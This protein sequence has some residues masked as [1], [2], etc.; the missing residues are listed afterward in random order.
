MASGSGKLTILM[1]SHKF[2]EV[3]KFADEVTILRRG[4]PAG[5]GQVADLT[6][7]AMARMMVGE[8]PPQ[9]QPARATARAARRRACCE[10]DALCAPTTISA[11]PRSPTSR[12]SVRAGEIVG[13][14]GVSGNG[15]EELVE[16]LAGQ[17]V[18]RARARSPSAA[19]RYR[20]RRDEMRARR[21][22]AC[23]TSRCATPASAAMS[24]AENIGFRRFD[25]HPFTR[26]GALVSG[27]ALR[28]NARSA[29]RRVRHP[30]A[31]APTRRS[32]ACRA[33]T[34]SAR[35]WRASCRRRRAADRLEPLLRP[36]LRGG[37]RDPLAPHG[38]A[39]PRR[40]GAADQR[41]PRRDLRAGRPD[42]RHQR[43]QAPSTRRRSPRPTWASSA[44]TWR[45][46]LDRRPA[47]RRTVALRMK[48]DD[49]RLD[50]IRARARASR[51]PL[52]AVPAR[53]SRSIACGA[54]PDGGA[55]ARCCFATRRAR[56]SRAHR[57]RG[58]RADLRPQR[59]AAR[60]ARRLRR[61]DRTS[62]TRPARA[63][64]SRAPRAASCWSSGSKPNTLSLDRRRR[65]AR[66][67]GHWPSG[68]ERR[69]GARVRRRRRRDHG[70]RAARTAVRSLVQ[71]PFF[72]EGREVCHVYLLHPPGG[73][74]GGDELRSICAVGA[75][76][77]ALVTTPAAAKA[78]R[79]AGPIARQTQRC[80]SRRAARSSGCRRRRSSTTAPSSSSRRASSCGAGARSSASSRSASACRRAASRSRAGAAGRRSSCGATSA[81]LLDRARPL[82]RRRRRCSRRPGAWA[83]RRS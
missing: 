55:R 61:R 72:P 76:A 30:H 20:A 16:V 80:R 79:S 57:A 26:P 78:Y 10:I 12:C 74:V 75:G 83:A 34:C 5:G 37:G 45:A 46:M 58:D 44:A 18:A 66:R 47:I 36:R 49:L 19:P 9:R 8:E 29:D 82:R 67:R 25:R 11:R 31:R 38:G 14:A 52:A 64:P 73:L 60:R 42:R 48:R 33:A 62:S 50:E 43:G 77:H 2:R 56:A 51:L 69:A 6:P 17:R 81:P 23:P 59:R 70:S 35:C 63:T 4:R 3:M 1:I 65:R 32:A 24:V 71:R 53:G 15:Q 7:D 28:K 27:R 54:T 21:C 22:A 68:W 41:R 40:R 13:I 39:Q